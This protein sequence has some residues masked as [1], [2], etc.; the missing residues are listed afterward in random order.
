MP[1]TALHTLETPE[2]A[3]RHDSNY[4]LNTLSDIP[5]KTFICDRID[6]YGDDESD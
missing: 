5:L 3:V 1:D 6:I 4:H 2:T